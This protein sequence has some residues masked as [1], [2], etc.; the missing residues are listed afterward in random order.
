MQAVVFRLTGPAMAVTL[1]LLGCMDMLFIMH[2]IWIKS[3]QSGKKRMREIADDSKKIVAIDSTAVVVTVD[4][5][6]DVAAVLPLL[7]L[8]RLAI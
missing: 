6:S 2:F 4:Y 8:E 5:V 3:G 1:R 7:W